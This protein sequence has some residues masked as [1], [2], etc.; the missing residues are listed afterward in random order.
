MND[1][2]AELT[3][4]L[5]AWHDEAARIATELSK[6]E[7][8][9]ERWQRAMA[10]VVEKQTLAE[11]EVER[12]RYVVEAGRAVV[13]FPSTINVAVLKARLIE[14]GFDRPEEC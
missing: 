5:A 2:C 4:K 7:A 14:T 10:E 13:K 8:E 11:A 12:L 6:S 9:V 3:K 1:P